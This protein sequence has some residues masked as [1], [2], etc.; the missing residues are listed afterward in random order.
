MI[1]AVIFDMDGL[2]F[3][4]EHLTSDAWIQVGIR[5]GLPITEA[6]MHP[7][8]GLPLEGCI[9]IF[10]EKLGDDFDYWGLRKERVAYV[11]QWIRENG[12][13]VKPGLEE[14][15][16]WLKKHGYEIA[17]AT[18][19]YQSLAD[20]FLDIAGV[21]PY[22]TCRVYGDMI[23]QGKPAPDIFLHAAGMLGNPPQECLVL[24]DSYAGVEAGWRAGMTVIMIP[25][26]LPATEREYARIAM[27][28][29][30]LR[31]VIPYLA[32][33]PEHPALVSL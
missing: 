6:L 17:L 15:L 28:A 24:E 1:K 16:E 12:M 5:H 26:M 18:S 23:M 32:N 3:D 7:M 21:S 22:F 2:M 14:L 9:R 30:S 27:C 25:D 29:P 20:R 8:R 10:K 33:Q 31:E 19:T 4:T 13:P 11:D